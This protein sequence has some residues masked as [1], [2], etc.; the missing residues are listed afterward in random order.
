MSSFSLSLSLIL[1]MMVLITLY[2]I[3]RSLEDWWKVRRAE[4]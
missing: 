4:R 2:F 1:G 3:I